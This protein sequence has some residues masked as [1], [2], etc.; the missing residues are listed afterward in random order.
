MFTLIHHGIEYAL[1]TFAGHNPGGSY[2]DRDAWRHAPLDEL[3]TAVMTHLRAG[4]G[5]AMEGEAI[6]ASVRWLRQYVPED[7]IARVRAK[8]R[9]Q[10]PAQSPP[11]TSA[12]P[13]TRSA[14]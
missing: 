4:L 12:P 10:G 2:R 11:A 9:E 8:A 3:L 14:P 1:L 13:S 6:E 5:P 7:V